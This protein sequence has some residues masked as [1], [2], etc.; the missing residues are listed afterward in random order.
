MKKSRMTSQNYKSS[1]DKAAADDILT[2]EE[3][4]LLTK[5]LLA[6]LSPDL[7]PRQDIQDYKAGVRVGVIRH[8]SS[9]NQPL[10]YYYVRN[11]Q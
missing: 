2:V 9:P 4:D 10:A 6:E 7:E 5:H 8:T 3:L 11:G 1:L